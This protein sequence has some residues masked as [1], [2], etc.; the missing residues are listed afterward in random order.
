M[1]CLTPLHRCNSSIINALF[2]VTVALLD[3]DFFISTFREFSKRGS[4]CAADAVRML[5]CANLQ[6][7]LQALPRLA[8]V[9]RCLLDE[10][11]GVDPLDHSIRYG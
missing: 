1:R 8:E 3:T 6:L 4:V 2:T 11:F 10:R 9:I 5:N 7:S